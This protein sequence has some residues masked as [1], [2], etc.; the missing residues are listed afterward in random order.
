MRAFFERL[1]PFSGLAFLH[2]PSILH[3]YSSGEADPALIASI[4]A[5]AS[6]LPGTTSDEATIGFQCASIT[7]D[8]VRDTLGQ[9][10]VFRLQA[11]VLL[12]RFRLWTGSTNDALLM[13]PYLARSAF[14]LGL[15]HESTRPASS[16]VY[17]SHRRLMWAIYM[18]DIA[19][20]DGL[21]QYTACPITEIHLRLPCTE[22]DF[23]LSIKTHSESIQQ[24]ATSSAS[25]RLGIIGYHIRI[26]HLGDEILRYGKRLVRL[27]ADPDA[28]HAEFLSL[29]RQLE[30]FQLHLPEH[31]RYSQKNLTLRVFFP[32]LSRW[33]MT[34]I[35]WHTCHCQLFRSVVPT[36][37]AT[38]SQRLADRMG[39]SSVVNYQK[40]C[41]EHAVSVATIFSQLRDMAGDTCILD[42]DMAD[43]AFKAT[44]ILLLSSESVKSLL[45]VAQSDL[46][47]HASVCSQL[48]D[49]LVG[50][51]PA[52]APIVSRLFSCPQVRETQTNPRH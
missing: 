14:L 50:M 6:R 13:M 23:E 4:V 51:Y 29:E 35:L 31:E 49:S 34:H 22:D 8:I 26:A 36:I 38:F 7:H 52:V 11:L 9:P 32:R 12:L 18:L 28:V 45:G 27:R 47:R 16:F 24:G 39:E 43:S 44:E 48:A 30:A 10:S 15:N 33:V 3:L 46:L 19:L 42:M 20:A 41:L 2:K 5:V 40:K 1:H 17:E 25:S 37:P 21:Q